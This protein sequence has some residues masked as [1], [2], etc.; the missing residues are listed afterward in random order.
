MVEADNAQVFFHVRV[1]IGMV[2]GLGI[3]RV[4]TGL[5]KFVAHPARHKVWWVHI[6]WALSLLLTL[7]HFWWWEFRLA[8]MPWRFDRF[9]FVIAYAVLIF[10]ACALLF[11]DDINEY[12]GWRAYF[13]SRR[14]WI[15]GVLAA[16]FAFDVG[17]TLLKG[18]DYYAHF[19]IEYPLRIGVML[20]A[21]LV[22]AISANA[23][24]HGALAIGNLVYQI[25]W[26]VRD[27]ETL[28]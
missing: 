18:V 21:C 15:F 16:T 2:V 24:V 4:L 8:G 10:L 3:T 20:V 19:G 6:A 25:S 5:A 28:S 26:I 27:Y 12:D 14:R 9:G 13:L 1:V 17:D 23:R 11:P 22:A 7:I